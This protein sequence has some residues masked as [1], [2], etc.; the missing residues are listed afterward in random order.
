MFSYGYCRSNG[1][2]WMGAFPL[3]R[4]F[5]LSDEGVRCDGSGLFVGGAPMLTHSQTAHGRFAWAA[6]PTDEQNRDL[7]ARYGFPVDVAAKRGGMA[8][9][10]RAL[11]QGDLA[12][13]QI[14][15]LL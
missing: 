3:L 6:R 2:I 11:E 15:A 4:F 14:S 1:A 10:A 5:R 12:L 9:V 8:G 7:R 13:A